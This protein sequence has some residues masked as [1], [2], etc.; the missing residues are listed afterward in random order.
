MPFKQVNRYFKDKGFRPFPFQKTAWERTANGIHQLIQCPTGSGKTL[1]ATGAMIERLLTEPSL[2]GLRLLYVTPLRAMTKDL[3]LA[4]KDPFK[5]NEVRILARNS[6]TSAKDRANLFRKAPHILMTTPESL[7]VILSS[8]KSIDLFSTLESIVV[9]EWHDLMSSKRGVQMSLCLS[10]LMRLSNHPTITGISA[11][12]RDPHLALEAL[13]PNG[14]M[15]QLTQADIERTVTLSIAE[16]SEDS[17]LPWAGHLGL[18]LLRPVSRRLVPGQTTIL[19]TNTRNQAEQWYQALCIVRM[20]L[21]IALHHGS[22]AA[23]A[24]HGVEKQLKLGDI[25]CVVATSAL[26]LGVDFQAVEKIIQIGS[27]RSVSR[28]I[29]RAGRASHR[30]GSRTDVLLVPTNRLHLNEFSALADALDAESLEPIRPPE[31]CL[32]VLIQHLVTIALQEPWHPD[33]IFKEVTSSW[34]YRDLSRKTFNRLLTVLLKG[35]DSLEKYP[36]YRRLE[37]RGDGCFVLVSNHAARR[38]RMSIGTI[39]S[40]AYV[41]V[42]MRRGR[43][44]GEVEESFAGRLKPG[45]IF[46]FSGKRLETIRLSEGELIVKPAR[47]GKSGEVPRWTGGRLPLSETLATR[48]MQDFQ[49][50]RPLSKRIQNKEWLANALLK[51]ASIQGRIS[52]CPRQDMTLGERFKTRDGYHLC[53]YP[54]AGWLVH[55]ALGPLIATRIAKR[56]PATLTVTVNDYGV[57]ILSPEPEP[58]DRCVEDWGAIVS[59]ERLNSDLEHA[60]NLSEL[61]KRQFRATARIS[62]LIFEGYPGRQKSL[63]MLQTS[64]GLLFDVLS[65]YDP[66]HV[67][68]EQAKYDV[69]RDEFDMERLK[70]TLNTLTQHRLTVKAIHQPSPL[71]LPLVIDRLSARLSTETVAERMARLTRGFNATA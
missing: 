16:S 44:L 14:V 69:L 30:P 36:E 6:D 31:H 18:N 40:H 34:A 13:L 39:V 54:F 21:S 53:L 42:R 2:N 61:V 38:H 68:L 7:S 43:S 47:S 11:T 15:G 49:R 57:E 60:L 71:A 37:Q 8:P 24:R 25:D 50:Q 66:M 28:M 10:R 45:D 64:A 65:Q 33:S 29:Q 55:Q 22:L 46:R 58:L 62:G 48:V 4:L 3:E 27:P 5:A 17:R 23:S 19:F 1:A 51:T 67:L 63:R 9:D 26:D 32:D 12:L 20:D 59:P 52:H 56:I 70:K 35:S 41:R